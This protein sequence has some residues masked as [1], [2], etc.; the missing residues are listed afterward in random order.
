MIGALSSAGSDTLGSDKAMT[1]KLRR[2]RCAARRR[3]RMWR[4]HRQLGAVP[5]STAATTRHPAHAGRQSVS[6]ASRHRGNTFGRLKMM[7]GSRAR[8]A[9]MA[10]GVSPG[11]LPS[12]PAA[13]NLARIHHP[14]RPTRRRCAA[15]VPARDVLTR[16]GEFVNLG[17]RR[18]KSHSEAEKAAVSSDFQQP[19]RLS[20]NRLSSPC[21]PWSE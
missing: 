19:A 13:Y 2:G 9:I 7:R 12:S 10:H 17:F 21:E 1:C 14:P 11:C 3:R 16:T 5:P 18:R 15:V 20:R 4:G 6:A 8:H